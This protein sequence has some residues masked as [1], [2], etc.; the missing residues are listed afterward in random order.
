MYDNF[1]VDVGPLNFV[2]RRLIGAVGGLMGGGGIT[3]AVSGFMGGGGN[4]ASKPMGGFGG[5]DSRCAPGSF[6]DDRLGS[7]RFIASVT[8]AERAGGIGSL[9]LAANPLNLSGSPKCIPPF[10]RNPLTGSCEIFLGDRP[11]PDTMPTNGMANGH[12]GLH[13]GDHNPFTTEVQVRR[14]LPGHVLGVDNLC[15]SKR[16]IRNS[17]RK[18]P[19]PRRPLGT[20]GDLNAVTKATSFGRRLVANKK[21]IRRL[22]RDLAKVSG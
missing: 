2:H 3:G 9:M 5:Q 12:P 21:R 16:D 20:S 8:A 6:Y 18:Y 22:E 1:S 14:C 11:G 17:D 15:H 13:A 19:K 10:R 4:G 7:C